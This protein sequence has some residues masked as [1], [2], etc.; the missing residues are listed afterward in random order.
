MTRILLTGGSGF[1][2]AHVLET[3]LERGHSVVTTVRSS[4]KGKLILDAHPNHSR[5]TLDYVVVEDIARPNAF[6]KA[7]VSEPPFE[8]VVHTASPFHFKS[9]DN[10]KELLEPAV[11]GTVGL[12]KAIYENAPSVK[13]VVITSSSAAI[14]D[15]SQPTK[16][17]SEA[18]W[19]P[20]TEEE[21]LMGPANG[22]R[23]SKTFAERAAWKFVEEK[24]PN[25]TLA[26]CNPPLV[27]GPVLHHLESLSALNTSNERIRD[28]MAGAGKQVCPPSVNHL[29]VDVRDL[30][31][32][33][34]LAVE[35]PEAGG[36]R[37]FMV[38]S[39]F[40]NREIVEIMRD[41]FPELR[42]NLPSG[43]AA[44][45]PGDYPPQGSFGFD[46]SRSKQVL[47]LSFR[48]LRES[49]V[50]SVKSLQQIRG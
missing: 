42:D 20:I 38:G 31:L 17:F 5:D 28:L 35:K 11:N 34:A 30:A 41:A 27:F 14:L 36:Q 48:S 43:E 44:L 6:D 49:I 1:I 7:V 45:R 32:G 21:A 19:C 9:Q 12:L 39:K 46:N 16:V 18:D 47:G 50:D 33:H 3:L 23:A 10:Q 22:Y 26:V 29:F 2:A 13:R 8:A 4:Q 25:F 37:F 15:P 24:K 40:S